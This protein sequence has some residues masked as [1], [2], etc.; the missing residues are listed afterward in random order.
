MNIR[1]QSYQG[2]RV[3]SPV[4]RID[5]FNSEEFRRLLFPHVEHCKADGECLVIDL[6]EVDYISSAGLRCFMMADKQANA[7]GGHIVVAAMQPVVKEIF[8]ISRFTLVFESFTTVREAI[9]GLSPAVL[10]EFDRRQ[11]L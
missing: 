6:E 10:A 9:A 11:A 5:H 1:I 2:V 8:E 7:Q 3:L 4:G